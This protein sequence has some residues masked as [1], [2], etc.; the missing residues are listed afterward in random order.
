MTQIHVKLTQPTASGTDGPFAGVLR[1]RATA[2]HNS[3]SAIV[4]PEPF[5]QGL[6]SGEAVLTLEAPGPS[7]CWEIT[8]PPVDGVS[9]VRHVTFADTTTTLEYNDTATV[10]DVDPATLTPTAAPEAAWWAALEAAELGGGGSGWTPVDGTESVKGVVQLAS[11][12][13]AT[14]GTNTSKAVTPAGLTARVAALVNS[15]PAAL[16]TLNE[17]AAALGN[18]QNF[19]TTMANAL[20]VR[21]VQASGVTGL[22]FLGFL[23]TAPTS[24]AAGDWWVLVS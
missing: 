19:A 6:N 16:D 9:H 3:G 15:S 12:A 21:M 13:E 22:R 10:H 14:A 1:C 23:T 7:W 20:A 2:R 11:T 17:L 5:M 24:P 18:D 8:E 4:L